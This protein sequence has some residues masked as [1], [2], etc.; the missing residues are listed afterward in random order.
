M[1]SICAA[2]DR[3]KQQLVQRQ[4]LEEL[5]EICRQAGYRW[6]ERELGP[7]LTVQLMLLRVLCNAS[8][9]CLVQIANLEVSVQAVCKAR[10]RLPLQVLML[11]V[12]RLCARARQEHG[13]QS[14]LGL[15]VVMADAMHFMVPDTPK[16]MRRFGRY[17]GPNPTLSYP[18]P[19]LLALM[20]WS[21]GLIRKVIV[22]PYGRQELS[23]FCRM[24]RHLSKGDLV[25]LDRA[26]GSFVHLSMLA[27]QG[28]HA[29]IRLPRSTVTAPWANRKFIPVRRLGR[30]D[31]LV[32]WHRPPKP[33]G[34]M[35]RRRWQD[36]PETLLLRQIAY[37]LCR[38]G[39]RPHWSWLITTLTDQHLYPTRDIIALY[40][41]RW[42]IEVN[43]RDLKSTLGLRLLHNRSIDSVRK[44]ILCFVAIYN[45]VR[46][47]MLESAEQQKVDA[48]RISFR[49]ML[50]W[51]L[52]S[53]D[54]NRLT[55]IGVNRRRMRNTQPRRLK[56]Y[57]RRYNRLNVARWKLVQPP[58]VAR[59]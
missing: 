55:T 26:Y 54:K 57:R 32:R 12:E 58:F 42:Q 2:L 39:F 44:E 23:C 15:R 36:I 25:L 30:Q 31:Q 29:C 34:W 33:P 46:L 3:I 53:G 27:A 10:K 7:V 4:A 5:P 18:C 17:T 50:T 8:L 38:K 19:K 43:F 9:A 21:T 1:A 28:V 59:L 35:S 16:L 13:G 11:W 37:R 6:R 24:F 52:W 41:R 56:N 49:Q 20:D 47:A 51:M 14:W 48:D 45:L 40:N 22:L